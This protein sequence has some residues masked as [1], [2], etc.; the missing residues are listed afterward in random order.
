MADMEVAVLVIDRNL[1]PVTPNKSQKIGPVNRGV[2]QI[3]NGN[4]IQDGCHDGHVE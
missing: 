1:H 2:R 4:Q 3:I